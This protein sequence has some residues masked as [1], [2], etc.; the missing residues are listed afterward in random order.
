MV[1]D[2][3]YNAAV[4]VFIGTNI[5]ASYI[6]ELEGSFGTKYL[7]NAQLF[8]SVYRALR[9]LTLSERKLR[10]HDNKLAVIKSAETQK[11]LLKP[12][13]ET[14]VRRY[15]DKEIPYNPTC[16]LIQPTVNSIIPDEIDITSTVVLYT[17]GETK[18]ID[19]HF[20]NVSTTT[21]A[22]PP[23]AILCELQPV[24]FENIQKYEEEVIQDIDTLTADEGIIICT[25]GLTS[26]EIDRGEC[27]S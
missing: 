19:V 21:I 12:N 13:T 11:V 8:T 5:Q 20:T 7:Q 1:Q 27:N 24:S 9:C 22:V 2:S 6:N 25:E 17:Y 10:K 23:G 4:L 14:I 18:A 26:K 15:L 16:C 3:K